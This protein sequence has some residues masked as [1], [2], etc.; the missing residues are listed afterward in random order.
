MI[1]KQ[2]CLPEVFERVV[3]GKKNSVIH[4]GSD[5]VKV[6]DFIVFEE[7]NSA[8]GKYTGK[9]IKRKIIRASKTSNHHLY[10]TDEDKKHGFTVIFFE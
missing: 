5:A 4:V 8:T 3:A 2:K 7:F 1:V 10:W 9:K 6:G